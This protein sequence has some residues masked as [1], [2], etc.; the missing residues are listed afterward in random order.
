MSQNSSSNLFS[1]LTRLFRQVSQH[2][3]QQ[4]AM[5]FL[6]TIICSFAEI[7]SLG[8]V[9]PF[10]AILTEPDKVLNYSIVS[11]LVDVLGI[12]SASELVLPLVVI[13]A[14]AAVLAGGLRLIL[15]KVS[16]RLANATGA[17]FCVEV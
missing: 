10:I 7:I 12:A 2:R 6:L 4:F 9:V 16:V 14:T 17:D 1:L 3:R 13:F 11:P 15:L 5:L 8:S